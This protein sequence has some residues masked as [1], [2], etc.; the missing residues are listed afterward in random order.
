[1]LLRTARCLPLPSVAQIPQVKA[2]SLATTHGNQ[3]QW[4]KT[5]LS[6][7]NLC[8]MFNILKYP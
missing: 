8:E 5:W 2:V 3:G 4:L 6:A 7:K 1:M